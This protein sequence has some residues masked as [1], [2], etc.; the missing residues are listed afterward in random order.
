[1]HR[2]PLREFYSHIAVEMYI[3]TVFFRPKI[4][5]INFQNNIPTQN[6]VNINFFN[7]NIKHSPGDHSAKYFFTGNIVFTMHRD[8]L[9]EF[10]SH[11]AVE[12]YIITVLL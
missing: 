2:D 5:K 10:Y 4:A 8:P 11:I 3:I 6:S 7:I 12:M 9:K 1:M